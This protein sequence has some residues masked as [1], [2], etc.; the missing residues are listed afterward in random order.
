MGIM[1]GPQTQ[2]VEGLHMTDAAQQAY[3]ETLQAELE[4]TGR[5]L[6]RILR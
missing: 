5:E 3:E 1:V 4:R 6:E 2:C